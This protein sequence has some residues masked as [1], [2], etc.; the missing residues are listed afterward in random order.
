MRDKNSKVI[1]KLCQIKVVSNQAVIEWAVRSIKAKGSF[2]YESMAQEFE[3]ILQAMQRQS[4]LKWQTV[5]LF[6]Q[7][8][9]VSDVEKET[10]EAKLET[11]MEI[12]QSRM[13]ETGLE[14]RLTMQ[15]YTNEFLR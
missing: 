10:E 2:N 4:S 8:P 15:E 13:E 14:K 1:Q 12:D 5:T 7:K 6:Q 9:P 3:L 11:K